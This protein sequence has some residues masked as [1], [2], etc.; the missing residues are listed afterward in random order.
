MADSEFL[1]GA[2]G[3]RPRTRFVEQN[4][5]KTLERDGK[6]FVMLAGEVHN[7]TSSSA[8]WMEAAWARAEELG[9][10]TVLAPV[11]WELLEPEEG[12]F[13]FSQV[14]MLVEGARRH[15]LH[16]GILWFGAWKNA[17]CYYAPAWVKADTKRFRRAVLA[18]GEVRS[19]SHT[20][21][22]DMPY[23]TLSAFCDETRVADAHAF[24]QLMAHIREIDAQAGT[25]CAV[26][27]ENECGLAGTARDRSAEADA[28]FAQDVPEELVE[29]L[30]DHQDE[31]HP[32]VR[33]ALLEGSRHGSW[34]QVF[35][36]ATVAEEQFQAWHTASYVNAVAKAG[37][38]EWPLPTFVNA[39]LDKGREPGSYPSGG[40]VA[41][42]HEVWHVAAP[43]IDAL[44]A[45]IY[46]R[47][48]CDV[49]DA[50]RKQGN[51]LVV[52]ET[53]THSYAAP[54]AIWAVG[55]HHAA[56]YSPFGFEEMGQPF[57]AVQGFLFGMDVN[58]PALSTPQD[59]TV[60]A[61]TMRGLAALVDAAASLP[62]GGLSKLDAVISE[63][64]D[65][66]YLE[67]DGFRLHVL[68]SDKTPGACAALALGQDEALVLAQH[69]TLTV[70]STDPARPNIDYLSVEE[71]KPQ[72]GAWVRD[73]RLN[74]D[75]VA[76]LSPETPTLLRMKTLRY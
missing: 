71:G 44:G 21:L 20:K 24:S 43:A 36:D 76:F 27:V 4:G 47:T 53:V 25:V 7:S 8:S 37:K 66:Q 34:S 74:G 46:V 38:A 51:A 73:R 19:V 60:Y 49:C 13:D 10:N 48:F 52:P 11:S 3:M 75:E 28:A 9:L 2:E 30:L 42:A 45:D 32:D 35:A 40:P 55:H 68:F 1:H 72:D 59:P 56:C 39:W 64:G 33:Y 5:E 15:G 69:C 54:R 50:F 65:E 23:T 6:P 63:R 67:L 29:Y 18:N 22:C 17:Q 61:A 12:S 14:D 57:S 41:R 62:A 70:E 26:Q 31:L 58:D 16:L